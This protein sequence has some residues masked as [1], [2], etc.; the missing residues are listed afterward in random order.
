[1]VTTRIAPSPTGLF[2]IGT[3]RT[4]LIN[5]IFAKQNNGEFLLRMEDTDVARNKSEFEDDIKS[6]LEWLGLTWDGDIVYQKNRTKRYLDVVDALVKKEKA[7]T[8]D[9]AIWFKIPEGTIIFHDLIRGEVVFDGADLK[10]FVIMRSDGS[11]IFYLSGVV[12]D[13]DSDITHVIRGEEHLSNTPKQIVLLQALEWELPTYAHVPLIL[14]ADRSKMSKRKDPVSITHDFKNKGYLPEALI[15]YLAL[16]GWHE[17]ETQKHVPSNAEGSKLKTKKSETEIYNLNTL[18]K[19]YD[20]SRMQHGGAIFDR[21]KLENMNHHYIQKMGDDELREKL[22]AYKG[23]IKNDVY[24]RYVSIT[25]PRLNKFSDIAN[26]TSW[27]NNP[28]DHDPELLVFKKST[29]DTTLKALNAILTNLP[30]IVTYEVTKIVDMLQEVVEGNN[31]QN[32][33]VFWSARVALSGLEKSPPP[34]E[35]MWVLGREETIMR[36]ER[37]ISFLNP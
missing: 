12:D 2:H 26:D 35:L 19:I 1:M 15:N 22:N 34:A 25:K 31:L 17:S 8:K 32:G 7:Y 9:G 20:V 27:L 33:D 24:N 37:A 30:K 21:E 10:D 3:A 11:P 4:A 23:D 5:Y 28:V 13:H 14:N 36:I 29:K 6:G 16:L 18:I